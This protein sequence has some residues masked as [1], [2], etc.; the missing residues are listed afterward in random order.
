MPNPKH[1]RYRKAKYESIRLTKHPGKFSWK[2]RPIYALLRNSDVK[3]KQR[4]SNR[5]DTVT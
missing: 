1:C 5:E 3:S 4:H 2:F